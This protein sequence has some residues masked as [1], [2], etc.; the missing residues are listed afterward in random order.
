MQTSQKVVGAVYLSCCLLL[1]N[2]CA[3]AGNPSVADQSLIEQIKVDVSTE[4]DVKRILGQPNTVSRHSGNSS[5][6]AIPG[7]SPS[8]M[9]TSVE[10]WGYSHVDIDVDP[11][12]FIPIVGLFVGGATS[13]INTFTVVFD[14]NGVVRHISSSQSQG[15][16][17]MGGSSVQ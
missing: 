9:L 17:G 1:L 12:T 6:A 5:Y 2:G 8:A 10:S 3:T 7:L 4:E 16:S 15:H 14:G 13:N 11:T